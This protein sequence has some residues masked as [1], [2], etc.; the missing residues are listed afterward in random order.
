M[1]LLVVVQ[2]RTGSTRLPGKVLLPLAGKPLL[3]RMLE[4][5]RAAKTPFELLVATTTDPS[6]DAVAETAA[7]FD[8]RVYRGHA[9]DLLDRHVGAARH[10]GADVVVKI[11]SDCP[12][13]APEVVDRVLG[14]WLERGVAE[15]LDYLG[16]L[17]PPTYPDGNDVEVMPL[18]SLE[19]AWCEAKRP[20]EREHTTP[21]LWDQ[22]ERFRLANV[23][24]ETGLDYSQ[25]HRFTIDYPEDY[26]L[27]HAVYAELCTSARPVFSL[28]DILELLQARPELLALNARY[29]GTSWVQKHTAELRT[30]ASL[31]FHPGVSS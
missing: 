1:T 27:I 24:W 16:N 12:L 19:V 18:A 13:I 4:R 26:A 25:T 3:G 29:H 17:R 23:V 14:A 20:F 9:T 21:F 5:L 22:P 11:P 15:R 28:T 7:A 8:T 30:R 10:A 6:D 2:A 31:G